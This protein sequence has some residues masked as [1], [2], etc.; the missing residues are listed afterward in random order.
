MSGQHDDFSNRRVR[1]HVSMRSANLSELED[2][3]NA[4]VERLHFD[5]AEQFVEWHFHEIS[6]RPAVGRETNPGRDCLHWVET[7]GSEK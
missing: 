3:V 4:Y 2:F 7:I 5:L 6:S 1:F